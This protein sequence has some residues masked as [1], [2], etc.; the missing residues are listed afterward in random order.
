M[1]AILHRANVILVNVPGSRVS[2]RCLWLALVL[3]P[4]LAA[5]PPAKAQSRK[6]QPSAPGQTHQQALD[7][8]INRDID[9]DIAAQIAAIR[10]IDNHAH[11][12]LPPPADAT[13]RE[14][15]ALP[16]DNMEPET[17]TVAWTPANPQI[18]LAWKNI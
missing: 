16:V 8:D 18:P 12:V 14:F 5:C 2:P 9:P 17:D 13:D 6:H 11:P 15:D 10:L 1:P 3:S 7:H 4:L